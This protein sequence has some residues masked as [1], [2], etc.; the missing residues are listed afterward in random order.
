MDGQFIAV[1]LP[2]LMFIPFF[3]FLM[4]IALR[5]QN[6]PDCGRPLSCFRS[7]FTKTRRQWIE[8]G[9]LC[10]NCGCETTLAGEKVLPGTGPRPNSVVRTLLLLTLAV[11]IGVALLLFGFSQAAVAPA[12]VVAAPPVVAVPPPFVAPAR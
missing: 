3:V 5:R 8:G 7:P 1:W 2:S 6:C 9:V 4:V 12:P 11:G 10:Q